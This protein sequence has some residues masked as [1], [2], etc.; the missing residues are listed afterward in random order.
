M[1]VGQEFA[2]PNTQTIDKYQSEAYSFYDSPQFSSSP[3][4]PAKVML[5][6]C[7]A[8]D[9]KKISGLIICEDSGSLNLNIKT[10]FLFE[11]LS[12]F[13]TNPTGDYSPQ[14][15]LLATKSSAPNETSTLRNLTTYSNSLKQ[16]YNL[17][18][19][20]S[21]AVA[22]DPTLRTL[23]V[24]KDTVQ[25]SLT[26]IGGNNRVFPPTGATMESIA[27]IVFTVWRSNGTGTEAEVLG[28]G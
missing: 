8:I 21:A 6:I 25:N 22:G 1:M 17:N 19:A 11:C 9:K 15:L 16:R 4:T 24:G 3:R 23:L 18:I 14:T 26:K 10:E 7:Q 27:R 28:E 12:R 2:K 13:L 5:Q 20:H